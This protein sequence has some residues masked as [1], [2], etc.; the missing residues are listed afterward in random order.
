MFRVSYKEITFNVRNHTDNYY[1]INNQSLKIV[2]KKIIGIV[3][4]RK[5]AVHLEKYIL[6]QNSLSH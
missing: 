1:K 5:Y 4:R 6:V 3:K 2:I